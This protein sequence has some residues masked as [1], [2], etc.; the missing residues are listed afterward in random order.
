MLTL[1]CIV[2]SSAHASTRAQSVVRAV[3][4]RNT[5]MVNDPKHAVCH[6]IICSIQYET[7]NF[8]SPFIPRNKSENMQS[9]AQLLSEPSISSK[10]TII[11]SHTQVLIPHSIHSNWKHTLG[12]ARSTPKISEIKLRLWIPVITYPPPKV[13]HESMSQ[14]DIDNLS[15]CTCYPLC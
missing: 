11:L 8:P 2:G 12:Y 14:E 5:C 9:G 15:V 10:T 4:I 6:I 3:Y 1:Y 13:M 7:G